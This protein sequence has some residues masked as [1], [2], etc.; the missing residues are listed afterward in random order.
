[1]HTPL[2]IGWLLHSWVSALFLDLFTVH[3]FSYPRFITLLLLYRKCTA[4]K[5]SKRCYFTYC[6]ILPE[7][8]I[9]RW[10]YGIMH[11]WRSRKEHLNEIRFFDFF[12]YMASQKLQFLLHLS[13]ISR[14]YHKKKSI[15][16]WLSSRFDRNRMAPYRAGIHILE[17]CTVQYILLH[18]DQWKNQ[19]FFSIIFKSQY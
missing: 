5:F 2:K 7:M 15:H 11:E 4:K 10:K 17:Y 18:E 9:M 6:T 8:K 16:L 19:D 3:N 13:S 12:L 1:M 14:I